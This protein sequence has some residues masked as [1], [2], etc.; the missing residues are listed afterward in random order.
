MI[1]SSGPPHGWWAS[2][3]GV[4]DWMPRSLGMTCAIIIRMA[5]GGNKYEH[6]S[7]VDLLVREDGGR[8]D[9]SR[10]RIGRSRK[11]CP[12]RTGR[13]LECPV[14]W[15]DHRHSGLRGPLYAIEERAHATHLRSLV[16]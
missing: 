7:E 12:S 1:R 2:L 11:C 4:V 13:F 5:P 14:S 15:R 8:Q 10:K 6:L 3:E 9:H 16:E